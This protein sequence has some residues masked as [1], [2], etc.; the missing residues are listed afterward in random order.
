MN[1]I[2]LPTP[3]PCTLHTAC[4]K[5][6]VPC[7][8]CARKGVETLI[9]TGKTGLCREC[10]KRIGRLHPCARC[11]APCP[12]RPS[13]CCEGC[14]RTRCACGRPLYTN[15]ARARVV[16]IPCVLRAEAGLVG[17]VG[18]CLRMVPRPPEGKEAIC[19]GCFEV[20][21]FKEAMKRRERGA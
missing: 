1:P 6:V 2:I 8:G 5:T 13:Q 15:E 10:R 20:R 11:G 18:G 9:H 4:L 17:C 12:P 16:C 14:Y 7:W 21:A 19:T 3:Q